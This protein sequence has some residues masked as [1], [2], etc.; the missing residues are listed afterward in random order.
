M[1]REESIHRNVIDQLLQGQQTQVARIVLI[2]GIPLAKDTHQAPGDLQPRAGVIH[3]TGQTGEVIALTEEAVHEVVEVI[4]QVEV[5]PQV[6]VIHQV[7]VAHQAEAIHRVEAVHQAEVVLRRV[8][9]LLEVAPLRAGAP[10]AVAEVVDQ[11]RQ[12]VREG[13]ITKDQNRQDS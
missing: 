3:Q 8:E 7:E 4:H 1:H 6:E 9:V 2:K 11:D 13:A 10:Q 12:E 5:A